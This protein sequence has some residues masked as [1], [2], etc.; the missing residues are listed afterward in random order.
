MSEAERIERD[1]VVVGA[2]LRVA[3]GDHVAD[4]LEHF[5]LPAWA[6]VEGRESRRYRLM[7]E[8]E[9]AN[10]GDSTTAKHYQRDPLRISSW[11]AFWLRRADLVDALQQGPGGRHGRAAG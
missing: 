9:R 1:A 3:R 10:R 8:V 4:H 5:G 7:G 6:V 11:I 2:R